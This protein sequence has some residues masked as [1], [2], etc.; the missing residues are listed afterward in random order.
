M[1][2]NWHEPCATSKLSDSAV[3]GDQ[4]DG[5]FF[6][7]LGDRKAK[8][9]T[10]ILIKYLNG[11]DDGPAKPNGRFLNAR[12]RNTKIGFCTWRNSRDMTRRAAEDRI[13]SARR[14]W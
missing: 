2:D 10:A 6:Q 11:F 9:F 1:G 13:R 5:P 14:P 4:E 8:G 12:R 3:C 7:Y